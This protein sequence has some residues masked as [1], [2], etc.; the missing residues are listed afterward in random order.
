MSMQ[1]NGR[2]SFPFPDEGFNRY[3]CMLSISGEEE[4]KKRRQLCYWDAKIYVVCFSLVDR[5]SFLHAKE[6]VKLIFFRKQLY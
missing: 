6:K 5:T 4:N 1:I 3:I 2:Y